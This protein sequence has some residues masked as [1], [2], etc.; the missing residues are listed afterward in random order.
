MNQP[1]S[2]V[3]AS[4]GRSRPSASSATPADGVGVADERHAEGGPQ[5][6]PRHEHQAARDHWPDDAGEHDDEHGEIAGEDDVPGPPGPAASAYHGN[7]GHHQAQA[8]EDEGQDES[9]DR[10]D[11]GKELFGNS[12]TQLSFRA[13]YG[14]VHKAFEALDESGRQQ[15]HAD[16]TALASKHNSAPGPSVAMA[17]EYLEMVAVRS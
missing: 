1:R 3:P 14:P 8:G 7:A 4:V 12:V 16:L 15:L 2:T 5:E 10:A 6:H 13:N 17:S 11:R 9:T